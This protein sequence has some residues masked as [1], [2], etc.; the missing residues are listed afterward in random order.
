MS[1]DRAAIAAGLLPGDDLHRALLRSIVDTARTAGDRK[2]WK[3]WFPLY[4]LALAAWL[5]V[6]VWRR[7]AAARAA[8][9]SDSP[10]GDSAPEP[11]AA[12]A[13]SSGKEHHVTT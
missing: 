1:G 2:L 8:G 11:K 9:T 4:L 10:G 12:A 5:G 13:A 3:L 6:T 7:R